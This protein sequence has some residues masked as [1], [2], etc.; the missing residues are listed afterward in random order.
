[1]VN[2]FLIHEDYTQIAKLLDYKRLGKQRVECK[3][4]I[5]I[6]ENYYNKNYT[7]TG[8]K[9]HPATLMWLNDLNELKKYANCMIREWIHRGYKNTMETY[10]ITEQTKKPWFVKSRDIRYTHMASLMRK[11]PAYYRPLF[12]DIVPYRYTLYTYI[13]TAKLTEEQVKKLEQNTELREVK[14][15]EAELREDEYPSDDD[16]NYDKP[17]KNPK[18]IN[19]NEYTTKIYERVKINLTIPKK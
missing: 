14:L 15:R 18:Y 7:K 16:E 11:D 12:K 2:T 13:W 9:T 3:Q 6:I 19:L 1:M 5:T 10:I 4:L 17:D 8:W